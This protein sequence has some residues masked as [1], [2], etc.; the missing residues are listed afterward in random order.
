MNQERAQFGLSVGEAS[1]GAFGGHG[2]DGTVSMD[3]YEIYNAY[4]GP[5]WKLANS[6]LDQSIFNLA[7]VSL[8]SDLPIFPE[9]C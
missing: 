9:E 8:P 7:M 4:E 6:T 3:T 5:E 2:Q 1:L